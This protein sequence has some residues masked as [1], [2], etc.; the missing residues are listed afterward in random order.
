MR[1]VQLVCHSSFLPCGCFTAVRCGEFLSY[2][3]FS[4]WHIGTWVQVY[5]GPIYQ[6]RKSPLIC[7]ARSVCSVGGH[8]MPLIFTSEFACLPFFLTHASMT[9]GPMQKW[10]PEN[11]E[12]LLLICVSKRTGALL[13]SLYRL[14]ALSHLHVAILAC[15]MGWTACGFRFRHDLLYLYVV[16]LRTHARGAW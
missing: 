15:S 14:S 4:V 10:S 11:N 1:C 12:P 7:V 9:V 5:A 3:C 6:P 16:V 13:W 2:S 8:S